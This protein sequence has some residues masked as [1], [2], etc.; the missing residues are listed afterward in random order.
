MAIHKASVSSSEK[1]WAQ[2]VGVEKKN[3]PL[4][5]GTAVHILSRFRLFAA[6]LF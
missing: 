3:N 6:E 4:D 2:R 5:A 1:R